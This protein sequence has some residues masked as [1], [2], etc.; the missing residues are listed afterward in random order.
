MNLTENAQAVLLL[1]TYFFK[2][3]KGAAKP[4]TPTEWGR[5]ALWLKESNRVPSSLLKADPEETLDGWHDAKISKERIEEL[6]GRGHAMALALEKWARAGIWVLTRSDTAYPSRLKARLKTDAPPVLFGC[7]NVNLLNSGGLAV[8]GSRNVGSVDLQF[9]EEL[10]KKASSEGYSIVSGGARG[11]DEASMLAAIEA[12]GMVVGV[13]ADSLLRAVTSSKWRRGLMNNNLVLVSPFYPE[14][15]FNAGNAMARNKYIYC[16]ADAAIVVHSGLKGGTWNGAL[17]NLRKKWVPLWVKPTSDKEAGNIVIVKKGACWCEESIDR[18][19]IQFLFKAQLFSEESEDLF[20]KLE[21][22]PSDEEFTAISKKTVDLRMATLPQVSPVSLYQF[23]LVELQRITYMTPLTIKQICEHLHLH[24]SQVDEWV[25]Q[26]VEEKQVKKLIKPVRYQC[27][28]NQ[29]G[30][31][32]TNQQE[33][34]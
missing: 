16:L 3:V 31:I 27:A 13:L 33:L 1:T 23:F 26:G 15:G 5:F 24:K 18:L 9:T 28:E 34:S 12:E 4:L 7:G 11:V 25:K 17:E 20:A 21:E 6:L 10:G 22:Q 32:W 30:M 14:A 2:P 8:V 19:S 29:L